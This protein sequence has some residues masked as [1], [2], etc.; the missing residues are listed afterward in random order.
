ME[1]NFDLVAQSRAN[2]YTEGSPVQFVRVELLK[3]EQSGDNA[4]CLTF[5]NID[6]KA[7]T[8]LDVR[9]RCKNANG[10]VLCEDTF[11]Y[12]DLKVGQGELFGM[13][14]A[15]LVT[16]SI[17][18]SVDVT[19]EWVYSGNLRM[20]LREKKRVRLPAAKRLSPDM[21]ARLSQ[22]V[23]R[24]GMKYVPQVVEQ[25]WYCACGAFHPNQENTV[26]CSE[27]GGDRVLLQN[28]LSGIMQP[29]AEK[30]APSVE[31]PTRVADTA[32]EQP[33]AAQPAEQHHTRTFT[34]D[35]AGVRPEEAADRQPEMER[36]RV[37]QTAADHFVENYRADLEDQYDGG[38]ADD[39]ESDPRD[40]K[41][42]AIIR[43]VP[44][45]TVLICAAIALGGFLY[46]QLVL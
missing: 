38:D 37:P 6:E 29:E 32:A 1:E 13:D 27:C 42:E 39:E 12:Q 3:G 36:K 17:I 20:D 8:G 40:E 41:A 34:P 10:E 2:Y 30:P 46:C 25:G 26:Y 19:L 15:V 14:D 33:R 7:I 23:G 11:T 43:W 44:A 31:E 35:P 24:A 4:V 18:G 22:K 45:L 16:P 21:S 28:A 9:F 5:K